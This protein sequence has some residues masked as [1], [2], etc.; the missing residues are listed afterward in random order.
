VR[1]LKNEVFT[2]DSV[3]SFEHIISKDVDLSTTF[4]GHM[5]DKYNLI[6]TMDLASELSRDEDVKGILLVHDKLSKK[7]E[8]KLR[9]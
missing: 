2:C 7:D 5:S 4:E 3:I 6:K 9:V 1:K 8:T